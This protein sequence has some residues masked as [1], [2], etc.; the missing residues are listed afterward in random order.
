MNKQHEN[1]AVTMMIPFGSPDKNGN[2]Q[3]AVLEFP[4]NL[5]SGD[6]DDMTKKVV[7]GL[8]LARPTA[9]ANQ[10]PNNN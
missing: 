1:A 8:A 2:Y 9:T 5:S 4:F 3:L 10:L 6:F 7:G